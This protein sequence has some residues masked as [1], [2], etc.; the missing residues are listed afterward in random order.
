MKQEMEEW[1]L[2]D[3]EIGKYLGEGKFGKVYLARE[4]KVLS[5]SLSLNFFLT[6]RFVTLRNPS[7]FLSRWK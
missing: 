5:L 3:F 4:I 2:E 7:K 6:S 1:K